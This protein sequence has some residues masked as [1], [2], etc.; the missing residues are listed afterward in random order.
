[1]RSFPF[2]K[3]NLQAIARPKPQQ[4]ISHSISQKVTT[5]KNDQ[6]C[7]TKRKS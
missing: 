4:K 2:K 5:Y 7:T 3:V 1:V 6:W